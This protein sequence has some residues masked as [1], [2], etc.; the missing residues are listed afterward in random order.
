MSSV[1]YANS[2]GPT[3]KLWWGT[4]RSRQQ[5][6]IRSSYFLKGRV[7]RAQK[8]M[9]PTVSGCEKNLRLRGF[10]TTTV[11][12]LA[13]REIPAGG[14]STAWY[15]ELITRQQTSIRPPSISQ[16]TSIITTSDWLIAMLVRLQR[17]MFSCYCGCIQSDTKTMLQVN[18]SFN[19]NCREK[20]LTDIQT[21][22]RNAAD[23]HNIITITTD[24]IHRNTHCFPW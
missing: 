22:K 21:L 24:N 6:R 4:M 5:P 7:A 8:Q 13:H 23:S 10:N 16:E 1:H 2:V 19:V 9:S 14:R 11:N 17:C 12:Q 20:C 15:L 18:V 3:D